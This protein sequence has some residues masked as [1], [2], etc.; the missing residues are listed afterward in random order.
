VNRRT[1]L[2]SSRRVSRF[3]KYIARRLSGVR[4]RYTHQ[5][6][7]RMASI[8]QNPGTTPATMMG[9]SDQWACQSTAKIAA[10]PATEP[11]APTSQRRSWTMR[12]PM[13]W[14]AR[15]SAS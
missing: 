13:S 10:I 9:A 12:P 8:T 4:M 6:F 14:L 3:A 1:S 15:S 7:F 2:A 11:T 5:V